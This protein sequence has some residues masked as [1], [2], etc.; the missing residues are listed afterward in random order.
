MTTK[1]V[2][3]LTPG[4]DTAHGAGT[5]Y[6]RPHFPRSH[7]RRPGTRPI[8]PR[9]SI[10]APVDS[11]HAGHYASF[12]RHPGREPWPLS[13]APPIRA[14]PRRYPYATSVHT[15]PRRLRRWSGRI[16]PCA[17]RLRHA[18][19]LLLK[20]F[21]QLHYFSESSEM[22]PRLT[23]SCRFSRVS[24]FFWREIPSSNPQGLR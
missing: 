9:P 13:I 1:A 11:L 8:E 7:G 3:E 19:L 4:L 15:T 6:R 22:L 17:D 21:Q 23:Q 12:P 10:Y 18:W 24:G 2:H 16:L 20:C 5:P 14:F